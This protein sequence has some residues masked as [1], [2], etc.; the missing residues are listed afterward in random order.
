MSYSMINCE[1]VDN[2]KS[3]KCPDPFMFNQLEIVLRLPNFEEL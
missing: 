1:H 2:A 3:L